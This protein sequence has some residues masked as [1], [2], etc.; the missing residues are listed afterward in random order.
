MVIE[1]DGELWVYLEETIASHHEDVFA[2]LTTAGGLTRWFPVAAEVDLRQGGTI[3]LGWDEKFRRKT[4][5]SILDYDP[6]G[7]IVWDWQ[8]QRSDT[9][10]PIYWRVE[11]DVEEGSKVEFRQG[12][13]RR[14]V[15][16]LIA[17]ADEVDSWRWYLCNLRGALEAKHD[18]R[19]V[20]PL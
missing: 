19:N 12:P 5:I 11:P 17:L 6:G 1:E 15:E 8:A 16:S 3:V 10:A 14:D 18:M 9:H 2:C 7:M 4:T 13:F 20:R